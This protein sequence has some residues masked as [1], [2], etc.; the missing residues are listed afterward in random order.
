MQAPLRIMITLLPDLKEYLEG[1]LGFLLPS[2]FLR[3]LPQQPEILQ[4][5]EP[6][7]KTMAYTSTPVSLVAIARWV[8]P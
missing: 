2:K 5:T 3:A 6:Q 4:H 8:L 1:E 7:K